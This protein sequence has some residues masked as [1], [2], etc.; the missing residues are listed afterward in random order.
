MYI[1]IIC[2]ITPNYALIYNN[3]QHQINDQLLAPPFAL[4][5]IAFMISLAVSLQSVF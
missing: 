2:I 4:V 5:N 1:N 3:F